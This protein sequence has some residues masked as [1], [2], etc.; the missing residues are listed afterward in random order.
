MKYAG[1]ALAIILG[2]LLFRV[3]HN[4]LD[5]VEQEKPQFLTEEEFWQ[6]EIKNF[7][8]TPQFFFKSIPS[9]EKYNNDG[10]IYFNNTGS[11]FR[12]ALA[13]IKSD[14]IQNNTILYKNTYIF[15]ISSTPEILSITSEDTLTG[16]INKIEDENEIKSLMTTYKGF[17][18]LW[19]LYNTKE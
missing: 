5:Q 17:I 9:Y 3:G 1:Y 10:I 14:I 2:I 8:F 15:D 4:L 11:Y 18:D 16:L 7:D 12:G 19:I 13:S 6:S